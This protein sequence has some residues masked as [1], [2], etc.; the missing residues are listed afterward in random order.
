VLI[1]LSAC[2]VSLL[3]ACLAAHWPQHKKACKMIRQQQEQQQQELTGMNSII[4]DLRCVQ[5]DAEL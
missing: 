5:H 2:C 4:V 1:W 3:Q